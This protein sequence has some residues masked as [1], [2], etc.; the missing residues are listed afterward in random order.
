M[1]HMKIPEKFAIVLE[2]GEQL[3]NRVYITKSLFANAKVK[4]TFI[5]DEKISKIIKNLISKY[6]DLPDNNDKSIQGFDIITSRSKQHIEEL[7]THYET[8]VDAFDWK[9]AAFAFL[10]EVSSSLVGVNFSS[11]IQLCSK[12]L[13]L[14]VMYGKINYMVSLIGDRRIITA[15]YAKL[16]HHTRSASEPTYAKMARWINEFENPVKKIQEEFR[17]L[18]DTIGTALSSFE[19]TYAKRRVITQLRKDG[20]LNLILKPEDIARPV[21]DQYRI[22]LAYASRIYQW[23]LYG[24]LFAPGTLNTPSS[25]ELV[26]FTLAEGFSLPVF[27]DIVFPIHNEFNTLFKTY[28]S[29]TINLQKQKK[30]IKDSAQASTQEAPRKHAERRVYIRQELEAMWNLFRDKPCLL[31]PKINVLLAALSLAKEEIF[32]YFRHT[33]VIPP[34]K[35]KKFYNKQNDIKEKR[36]SSLLY[37]I[38]HLVNLVHTHKKMI[39]NYYLEYIAGADILGLNKVITPHILQIAGPIVSATLN[40]ITSELKNLNPGQTDYQFDNLRANWLRLG[41]LLASSSCSLKESESKQITSRLNLIYIHSKNVDSLN[42]LLDE[43]GNLTQLWYHREPLLNV[44]DSSIMEGADQPTHCMIFLKLLAQFPSVVT[45]YNP[46]EKEL[47]G[48]ECVD[49]ANSCLTK[50]TNRIVQILSST[51]V[52]TFLSNDAQLADVNAAFPLLQKRKDWKPP[53]DFVPP[54]EPGTETQFRNRVNLEQLR[55]YEKNAFQLCTA[56]NELMDI[57]I[58]DHVFVPREFL[59]EKLGQSL[60][61]FMRQA[62]LPP[63]QPNSSTNIDTTIT[64][65]SVFESQLCVFLGVMTLVEN[66]L[67]IDVGDLIRET[68]LNEFYA[69][70]LGKGCRIDWFPEGEIE[71]N[72]VTLHSI[73]NFYVDMVTKKLSTPGVVYSSVKLGFLSKA[74]I[75][76]RAEDHADLTE[77]RALCNLVGPY[78]IKIIERELLRFVLTTTT[79]M[80]EILSVN[81]ANLEEFA[82]NFYKPKAVELLKKFKITD[83]DAIVNKSISIGNALYLRSM[84][85]DAMSSVISDNLPYIHSSIENAFNQYNRNTFMFPE[86]L[87]VDTLALDCGLDVGVA[88]Q[89]LK[90]ILRKVSNDADK[91]IWELLPVMFSLTFYS[92]LWKEAQFKAPIDGH[93]NDVHVL[94]K[95]I[96]DL[97][98]AFGAINSTTGNESEISSLFIRFLEISSINILRMFRGKPNEKFV[99]NEIQSVVVFLDKFVQQC[100]LLSK[101]I[102]DSYIPY[103]LIRNMYKDL[104]ENKLQKQQTET[105]EQQF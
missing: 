45:Q 63:Q 36:I 24:Y 12:F 99:P 87:G 4:P 88:D 10:Q 52:S 69:K 84:M 71:F 66:Y 78:G 3:L 73:S 60:K 102:L 6:P 34:E 81:A 65:P 20:A 96:I 38:D 14:I 42:Q 46:E 61:Q 94:S 77:M 17:V 44:F 5:I 29:K 59:R 11:N 74:G 15:V 41:Y 101:D 91:R 83:L 55:A 76:F 51:V 30:L 75:P 104:Y 48:K 19:S 64:R 9:E 54:V 103:S 70:A 40:T 89:Y 18:N 1:A 98:I 31:A 16:F 25:I 79:S 92:T 7:E 22:E 50:I 97:L 47:V 32:W 67:D 56:L 90:V 27:K 105:S 8:L 72:D 35:V 53:K 39:Q 95:T 80:K 23:I 68:L 93:S 21:Q 85:R 82:S 37:L 49:L 43:Y 26:R 33:D 2:N 58:F 62:I 86:F 57:V 100:P 28:K 13:D